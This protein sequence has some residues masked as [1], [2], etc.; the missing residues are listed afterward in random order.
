M[1]TI[2]SCFQDNALPVP[3]RLSL[4]LWLGAAGLLFALAAAAYGY[5]LLRRNLSWLEE[6]YSA[7]D[8]WLSASRRFSRPW[9][10]VKSRFSPNELLGLEL[11]V[12]A[13]GIVLLIML[14]AEILEGWADQDT[15]L[16]VDQ[17]VHCSLAGVVGGVAL[18]GISFITHFADVLTL[19]VLGSLLFLVLLWLRKWWQALALF[20]AI[21]AGQGLLW[22]MKWFFARPR[23]DQQLMDAVGQSFPSGHSFSAMVFYGFLL[24]LAWQWCAQKWLR[25]AASVLLVLLILTIGVSR[26]LLS[27]HWVSDVIGGF[28]I[29]LAWLMASLLLSRA[30][31]A[32][33]NRS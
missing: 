22:G 31:F 27:V 12:S 1:E 18:E 16:L 15:L 23:P 5:L 20:L 33:R 3:G 25:I 7:L 28:A 2:L 21:A 26:L 9:R 4:Y 14:F 13:G 6:R 8:R 17:A 30:W 11:T 24:L 32:W 19:V 29:G 10:F